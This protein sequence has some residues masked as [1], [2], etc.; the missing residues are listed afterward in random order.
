MVWKLIKRITLT[1]AAS[2][3]ASPLPVMVLVT[4]SHPFPFEQLVG[5]TYDISA[6]TIDIF[7]L[8]AVCD[9]VF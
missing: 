4:R 8:I 9:S 3:Q 7:G 1:A 6:L 5:Q 2:A